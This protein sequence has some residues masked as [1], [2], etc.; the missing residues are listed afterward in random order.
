M[1]S[2]DALT[3]PELPQDPDGPEPDAP[4]GPRDPPSGRAR[5]PDDPLP[6]TLPAADAFDLECFQLSP[7]AHVTFVPP[8]L[9][10]KWAKVLSIVMRGLIDAILSD[11][12]GR[13]ERIETAARW[14]LGL[15]QLFLREPGRGKRN[16]TALEFR[17]TQ[18]LA[19]DYAGPLKDWVS[20]AKRAHA[21]AKPAKPD[22][23]AAASISA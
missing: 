2:T 23:A 10:E 5:N 13:T 16:H 11:G 1:A 15:P 4:D 17:L 18:F 22:T 3:P 20:E 19:G 8:R 6:N 12:P 21:K 7:F 9:E 14:Y